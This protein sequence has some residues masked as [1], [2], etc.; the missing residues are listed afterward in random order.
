[1]PGGQPGSL[2]T[3]RRGMAR[4]ARP[5][6]LGPRAATAAVALYVTGVR[7]GS[8]TYGGTSSDQVPDP[9]S[10]RNITAAQLQSQIQVANFVTI[11]G[12]TLYSWEYLANLWREITMWTHPR[13]LLR[14]QIFLFLLVRYATIPSLV[15]SS[16]SLLGHFED[17]SQCLEHEQITVAVVQFIVACI[18]S[19]RTIAIWR[20]ARW[21]TIFLSVLTLALL[22]SSIS[23]LYYSDDVLLITGSCRPGFSMDM[24]GHA[25]DRVNTVMWFYLCAMVFDTVTLVLSMFK[26]LRYARMG[27]EINTAIDVVDPFAAFREKHP[28]DAALATCELG[29][30]PAAE[31][32]AGQRRSSTVTVL[33]RA[34]L[35]AV[36]KPYRLAAAA[37]RWWYSLT[38]LVARLIANGL[39][40]FIAATAFN[41]NNFVLEARHSIHAKSFLL[42]YA[43]LMCVLC[44]RM[45]LTE[46]DAVW[47]DYDPEP[48]YPGRQLMDRLMGPHT[49]DERR[50]DIDRFEHFASVVEARHASVGPLRTRPQGSMRS[51]IAPDAMPEPHAPPSVASPSG[52]S[53]QSSSSTDKLHSSGGAS[54]PL[55][56][57]RGSVPHIERRSSTM[58]P[59]GSVP[60]V[61]GAAPVTVP[62]SHVEGAAPVTVPSRRASATPRTPAPSSAPET[63]ARLSTWQERQAL[64]MAGFL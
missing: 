33:R 62:M 6:G 22:G 11:A 16:Y 45:L 15:I 1:M 44:Q 14:P 55:A 5:Y 21:I 52:D 29:G 10:N 35:S 40:Y 13:T 7:A 31:A 34:T 27:R 36:L 39:V 30:W 32:G 43:P 42:L 9:T 38:P 57:P 20:R 60:H 50:A 18:F 58:D 4:R 54:S 3:S 12:L 2:V 25:Q 53:P 28:A 19:W 24:N 8:L 59:R 61:D 64:R 17:E 41:L 56:S 63:P 47:S 51:G 23:L 49:S 37:Y 26:L 46:L 48:N